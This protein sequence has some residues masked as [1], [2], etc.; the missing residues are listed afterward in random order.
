MNIGENACTAQ[1]LLPARG[2]SK[3]SKNK[4]NSN[5]PFTPTQEQLKS[6]DEFFNSAATK[7]TSDFNRESAFASS[8]KNVDN[9][10]VKRSK[11]KSKAMKEP[12]AFVKEAGNFDRAKKWRML[13]N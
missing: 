1:A 2:G 9:H 6:M 13:R 12:R 3:A 7:L 8:T 5:N 4:S 11:N 10:G